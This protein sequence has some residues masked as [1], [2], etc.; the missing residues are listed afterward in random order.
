[1]RKLSIQEVAARMTMRMGA[2]VAVSTVWR[3]CKKGVGGVRLE[4]GRIGRRYFV[5]DGA[6]ERFEAAVKAAQKRSEDKPAAVCEGGDATGEWLTV[7]EVARML[8]G[9]N[10]LEL[11]E[12]TVW[13][14]CV[15]G[16]K[17]V[18]LEHRRV[19]N[20][21]LV[22]R[23]AID[24]FSERVTKAL[25]RERESESKETEGRARRPRRRSEGEQ[26]RRARE[27]GERLKAAGW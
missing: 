16:L 7:Q 6:L 11:R 17:G 26:A 2:A 22:Q 18:R 24:R 13:R 23:S 15:T 3:W 12:S 19:G 5:T 1:M 4:H 20:R 21:L 10:S 14:W 9:G 8:R 27:A 25:E